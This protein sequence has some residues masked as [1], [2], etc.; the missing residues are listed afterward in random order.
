MIPNILIYRD[1]LLPYS[2]TFI[3]SQVER[4][5]RYRGIYVGTSRL[6]QPQISIP[7]E[8]SI[9]LNDLVSYPE[10]WKTALKLAGVIHPRWLRP[11]K[12]FSPL[13]VHAHFGLDALWAALFARRLH[14][15]LMITFRGSDITGMQ[16]SRPGNPS[17]RLRDFVNKRGQFYRDF[18]LQRRPGLFQEAKVS[19]GVSNF[20]RDRMLLA[21]CPESKA[22]VVYDGVALEQFNSDPAVP[23]QPIVLFVGRL[24]EKKGC[25]YLI[26]AMARVQAAW[27][28]AELV[29]IGEGPLRSA[30]E[31]LAQKLLQT[32]RFLGAQS[33][34]EV[35]AWMNRAKVLATPSVTAAN[36]DSEGLPTVVVEAQAMAL[37]VV[38]TRHAGIPE[39]VVHG[40][41]GFL[42]AEKDT[43]GL[44]TRIIGLLARPE[45]WQACAIAARQHM[46][47]NFDLRR[48]VEKL[49]DIYTQVIST[50]TFS[51]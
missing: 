31:R 11:I 44:A 24:V 28:E 48:N 17:P 27:P 45:L 8:K 23:R 29:V 13:L 32:Y 39:A 26:R 12:D 2:E 16:P 25:E 37:P 50:G 5:Q 38:A 14:L 41:T 34:A 4:L 19:I 21:G 42:V 33:H 20:I 36:G 1:Q 6:S 3:P 47:K 35:T 49:E 40:K 46:E 18:Y 43:E 30:L 51:G 9:C 15:P 10:F 7:L 22:I